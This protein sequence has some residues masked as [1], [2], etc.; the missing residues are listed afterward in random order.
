MPCKIRAD[1]EP[2]DINCYC[3]AWS[4]PNKAGHLT[5]GKR[6]LSTLEIAQGNKRKPKQLT[7]FCQICRGFSHR[8]TDCWRQEK[9]KEHRPKSWKWKDKH[10]ANLEVAVEESM[11][12]SADTL[13]VEPGDWQGCKGNRDEGTAD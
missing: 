5:K 7:R 8:T 4:A 2:D 9:N 3:P 10:A 12:V 13:P 6:R 1:Y 11:R